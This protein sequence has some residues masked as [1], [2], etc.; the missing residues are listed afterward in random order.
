MTIF[1][2]RKQQITTGAIVHLYKQ[3]NTASAATV[4]TE[5]KQTALGRGQADLINLT[6]DHD[7]DL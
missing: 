6:H 3:S 2:Q 7:L 5:N 4:Y 1:C